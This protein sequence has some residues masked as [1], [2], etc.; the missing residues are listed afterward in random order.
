MVHRRDEDQGQQGAGRALLA[1]EEQIHLRKRLGAGLRP[2]QPQRRYQGG[3]GLYPH[4]PS[5]LQDQDGRRF[6]GGLHPDQAHRAAGEQG[7]RHRI[8][9]RRR[10]GPRQD[11]GHGL[12]QPAQ[13]FD[14]QEPADDP[15]HAGQL[16]LETA[17]LHDAGLHPAG[18]R[19]DGLPPVRRLRLPFRADPHPDAESV[20]DRARGRRLCGAAAAR[21][22][23]I[24]QPLRSEGIRRLLHS[25]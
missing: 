10:K 7:E 21:H 16:R 14:R 22:L 5:G 12:H 20:G 13:E 6:D 24:R 1:A 4:R 18:F 8:G 11:G 15:R 2:R 23:Q 9:H 17:Y 3:D 19:T 25:V